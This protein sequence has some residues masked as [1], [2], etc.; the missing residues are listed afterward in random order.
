MPTQRLRWSNQ[1]GTG[2]THS[3]L[4]TGPDAVS[5]QGHHHRPALRHRHYQNGCAQTGIPLWWA[6]SGAHGWVLR[7]EKRGPANDGRHSWER[8]ALSS[9]S[10]MRPRPPPQA[11]NSMVPFR[12]IEIA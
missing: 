10:A 5:G 4:L 8:Q 11:A 1:I 6:V 2:G 3:I 7:E 12:Q 9:R